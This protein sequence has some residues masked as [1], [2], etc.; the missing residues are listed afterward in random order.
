MN[1]RV[2]HDARAMHGG[3]CTRVVAVSAV[4][5]V[6]FR[7]SCYVLY[8]VAGVGYPEYQHLAQPS[9]LQGFSK[10]HLLPRIMEGSRSTAVEHLQ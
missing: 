8:S 2:Y 7:V 9:R 6:S 5:H 4:V 10:Y 1:A 3:L